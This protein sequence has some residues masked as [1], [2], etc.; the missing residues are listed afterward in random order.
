MEVMGETQQQEKP[1]DYRNM[2]GGTVEVS[3]KLHLPK[4]LYEFWKM[5]I[6]DWHHGNFDYNLNH[7]ILQLWIQW[8]DRSQDDMMRQ[9]YGDTG[10]RKIKADLG[11]DDALIRKLDRNLHENIHCYLRAVKNEG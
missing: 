2:L 11:I 6:K 3:V 4:A 5:A 10:L 9:A 7:E 1:I 8:L